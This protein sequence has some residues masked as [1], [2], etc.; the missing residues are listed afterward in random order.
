MGINHGFLQGVRSLFGKNTKNVTPVNDDIIIFNSV[1]DLWELIPNGGGGEVNDGANVGSGAGVFKTKTGVDL[2]FKSLVENTEILI[3]VNADDLAFSIGA[4]AISKITGLQAELDSKL[5]SPILISDV[6]GLQ[7][8]L[9]DKLESPIAISD[10][11]GL[12]TALD[13]KLESPIAISDTT[14][15]QTELDS[16]IE[17]VTNVGGEKELIKAKVSQDIPVRTLKEGT[18]I[19]ITQNADDLEIAFSGAVSKSMM[20]CNYEADA[21]AGNEFYTLCGG[22]IQGSST[23]S[24][25]QIILP[26]AITASNMSVKLSASGGTT[27]K[28]RRG[29]ATQNQS[30]ITSL[31][32]VF[33]DAVNTDPEPALTLVNIRVTED[34]GMT[35]IDGASILMRVT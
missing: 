29:G 12:Q 15:L 19:T 32:G 14:G 26:L 18:D 7:T 34:V 20:G 8:E 22:G 21:T 4:I 35:V 23:E 28:Y 13:D 33:T 11:T 2:I 16:K 30:I 27:I 24:E 1:T 5:E 17:T 25:R 6:T 9:D 3:G 31:T 10:T